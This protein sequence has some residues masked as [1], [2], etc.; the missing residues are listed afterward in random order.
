MYTI[1]CD[2]AGETSAL[3]DIRDK[4]LTVLSPEITEEINRVPALKFQ[5]PA[6]NVNYSKIE[7]LKSEIYV[8][9]E[10]EIFRGR[11]MSEE[12]D[13][14]NNKTV[15]CEGVLAY[16]LD[17]KYPPY[18]HTGSV[19]EFV[20][21][22]LD[23]HNSRVSE[24][25]RIYLGNI[26]VTDPN[27]YIRRESEDYSEI[28]NIIQQ[29]LIEKLGG[30]LRIRR[31]N[32]KNYLDYLADY[33]ESGQTARFGE[34]ILDLTRNAKAET[35]KTVIIPLGAKNEETEKRV[36]I[37]SVNNGVNYVKNN[38]LISA[39]GWI[40]DVVTWD[41]VTE[42]ANLLKKAQEYLEECQ[43]MEITI[44]MS[45][46]DGKAYGLDVSRIVPGMTVAVESEPHHLH[47]VFLCS[48]K[49]TNLLNP[50]QDKVVLGNRF[51]TFTETI[52]REQKEA[53]EKIEVVDKTL[54]GEIK[55]AKDEFKK[56]IENASG[57][58][59]TDV[60]QENGSKV[61]YYHDKKK[62]E[63]SQIQMVF[64]TAG[65]AITSDGGENWYGMKVDGEFI[66]NILKTTGIMAEWIVAGVLKSI[67][68]KK[69]EDGIAFDLNRNMI[70]S[71]YSGTRQDG[72]V[73]TT[74][75]KILGTSVEFIIDETKNGETFQRYIRVYPN[76][77]TIRGGDEGVFIGSIIKG[78]SGVSISN[79]K[80]KN[81]VQIDPDNIFIGKDN[82]VKVGKS[83]KAEFSDG[84]Y[85]EFSSG[86]LVGGQ[87]ADGITL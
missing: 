73:V 53:E 60:K 51:E 37:T 62:L 12:T 29:K 15:E 66:A 19:A 13:F 79:Q 45:M 70:E 61:T 38:A 58:Y 26:T 1:Q 81:S 71:Y 85:L 11:C 10:N 65:F 84:S 14:Y 5:I 6:E 30:W 64:N 42:P 47:D 63:D 54:S 33:I 68:F 20:K 21:T 41:D 46:V 49:T 67:D 78:K 2:N 86:I 34:N 16:L 40:E 77:L 9:D 4:D 48:S 39:Y 23:Y 18:V 59:K 82:K 52:N 17:T 24:K 76:L 72:T 55:K 74:Q 27:N 32:G 35:I 50:S 28:Y 75:G 43:N 83:G 57:L 31:V 69:N 80:T 87:T 7:K 22:L 44:E 25:Q 8:S 56:E 36:D 3:M